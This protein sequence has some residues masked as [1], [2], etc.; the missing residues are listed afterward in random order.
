M[1]ILLGLVGDE[2]GD[3]PEE[4]AARHDAEPQTLKRAPEC[5]VVEAVVLWVLEQAAPDR[6][7]DEARQNLLRV[8]PAPGPEHPVDL[9]QG[10]PPGGHMVD[11]GEVEDRVVRPVGRLDPR[12]VPGPESGPRPAPRQALL[13]GARAGL[14]I[15]AFSTRLRGVDRGRGYS[16]RG[17][18][19]ARGPWSEAGRGAAR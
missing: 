18:P 16:G 11:D 13:D 15:M 14:L 3:L 2:P 17:A 1:R 10:L 6:V 19:G 5:V 8:E 7:L 9:A 4:V 12:G